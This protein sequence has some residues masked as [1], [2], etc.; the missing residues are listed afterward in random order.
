[1]MAQG[2]RP[3]VHVL[4]SIIHVHVRLLGLRSY[5]GESMQLVSGLAISSTPIR[6]P[7]SGPMVTIGN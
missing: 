5:V 4:S 1:M 6:I 7:S 2:R 3:T